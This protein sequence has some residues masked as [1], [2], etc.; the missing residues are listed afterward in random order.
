MPRCSGRVSS[1]GGH[2]SGRSEGLHAAVS[3][4]L[5]YAEAT[6]RQDL[7]SWVGAHVGMLESF[8]GSPAIWVPDN[9]KSGVTTVHAYEPAINR[10]YED[11][12]Q[13]D[14]AVVIPT[15]VARPKDK[16]KAEVSVQMAHRW[17]LAALR[18]QTFFT[19][20]SMP[21]SASGSTS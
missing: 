4:G 20:I 8:H 16:P 7:P 19:L 1:T 21:R 6:Y 17:V 10:T 11:L 9:L 18:Q 5:I 15:R 3:R 14:G 2:T 12:A 13:H